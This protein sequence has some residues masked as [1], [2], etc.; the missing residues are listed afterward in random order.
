[1]KLLHED[2][3]ELGVRIIRIESEIISNHD[4]QQFTA[5][6]AAM[7]SNV[8]RVIIDLSDVHSICSSAV[9]SMLGLLERHQNKAIGIQ[10]ALVAPPAAL[11][12]LLRLLSPPP[13]ITCYDFTEHAILDMQLATISSVQGK[14]ELRVPA[15][16]LH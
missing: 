13:S 16:S 12:T 5:D 1:M 4:L 9:A 10:H 6:F 7:L 11:K 2:V 8:T 3:E 14:R 15:R